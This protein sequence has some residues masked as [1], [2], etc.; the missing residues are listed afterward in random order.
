VATNKQKGAVG[1][2]GLIGLI[3]AAVVTVEGGFVDNPNDPGGPT[4]HGITQSVARDN[5]FQGRMQDLTQADAINIYAQQYIQRPGYGPLV[6]IDFWFAE[7]IID[8]GVNA[9]P[10]RCS[11]WGQESLNHYNRRG[12]DYRDIS[13]DG[14][15]GPGSIAAYRA[16]QRKR[17]RK[18]ACELMVKAVD[19]KQAQHYMR[20]SG[21]DSKFET[22]MPGWMRTR[23]G[24][25]DLSKC[26]TVPEIGS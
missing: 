26:G 17:G 19:A 24:N 13:E 1:G 14:R 23:I 15:F 2:L 9:G 5:R 8:C 10:A 12:Q 25:V 4:N 3:I 11:R 6:E 20:L 7:E 21:H 18:T 22:F 16:L